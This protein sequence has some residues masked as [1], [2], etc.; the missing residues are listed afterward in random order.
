MIDVAARDWEAIVRAECPAAAHAVHLER[1]NPLFACRRAME[2]ARRYFV[3]TGAYT[4][5]GIAWAEIDRVRAR[6]AEL[7]GVSARHVV[8][9]VDPRHLGGSTRDLTTDFGMDGMPRRDGGGALIAAHGVVAAV[10]PHAVGD[11]EAIEAG[12]ASGAGV[13]ALGGALDVLAEIGIE[14]ATR[15]VH[16]LVTQLHRDLDRHHLDLVVRRP[17]TVIVRVE[18]PKVVADRL[19][20]TGVVASVEPDGIGVSVH[21]FTREGDLDR[22]VST[23][24]AIARGEDVEPPPRRAGPLVCVDLNGVLDAYEGWKGAEHWDPPAPG[25]AEFLRALADRGCR[26]I[27]FTTRYYRDAWRWLETHGL[28]PLVDQVTDRKPAADVFVDDRAVA[29]DGDF[30][31]AL[32]RVEAFAPHW[33]RRVRA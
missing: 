19:A 7:V 3:E 11:R 6:F 12:A 18:Q 27:L 5:H 2:E 16:D 1:A 15:R 10:T 9:C 25:A 30:A 20:S 26:I 29:F 32:R 31:A 14:A 22:A 13:L 33:Q 17:R 24:A 28:A 21:L 23:L 4:R 8:F